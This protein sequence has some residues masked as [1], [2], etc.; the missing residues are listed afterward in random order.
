M[1]THFGNATN[2]TRTTTTTTTAKT[3]APTTTT[4]TTIGEKMLTNKFELA[5]HCG[6]AIKGGGLHLNTMECL[7]TANSPPFGTN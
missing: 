4:T 3:T 2:T 7:A 1:F 5:R 6:A